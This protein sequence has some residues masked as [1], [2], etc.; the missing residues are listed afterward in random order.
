MET[1]QIQK[2]LALMEK[3]AKEI[4]DAK[5]MLKE[6]LESNPEYIEVVKEANEV[7]AKKKRI[8]E[9]ILGRGANAKLS[10]EIKNNN[11]EIGTLKEILSAE[12]MQLWEENDKTDEI[13]DHNGETRKFQVLAKLLP[14]KGSYQDRDNFGKY[15]EDREQ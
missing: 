14:K 15:K 11:E 3:Y 13:A 9:E 8:K 12:L 1:S 2:R 10:E 4:K 7:N 5:E 6:E